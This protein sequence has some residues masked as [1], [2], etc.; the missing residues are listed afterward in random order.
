MKPVVELIWTEGHFFDFYGIYVDGELVYDVDPLLIP[1]FGVMFPFKDYY[2]KLYSKLAYDEV[3][4]G[5]CSDINVGKSLYMMYNS[6][7]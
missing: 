3:M 7:Y 2:F 4:W 1:G 5:D 6:R